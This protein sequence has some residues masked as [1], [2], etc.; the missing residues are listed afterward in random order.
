[1]ASGSIDFSVNAY[2]IITQAC[3]ELGT[4]D[5]HAITSSQL[6]DGLFKLNCLVKQYQSSIFP[7]LMEFSRKRAYLFPQKGNAVYS[8]GVDKAANS[9]VET[10]LTATSP[11]ADTTLTVASI[12]GISAN[13]NIG[14]LLNTGYVQWTTVSGTPSG[15]TVTIATGLASSAAIGARV[16]AYTTTLECPL[17]ILEASVRNKQGTEITISPITLKTYEKIPDKSAQGT[18]SRFYQES[19]INTLDVYFDHAFYDAE[20]VVRMVYLSTID[21][22]DYASD[23]L[24]Y[25]QSYFRFLYYALAIDWAP[26]CK[27]VVSPELQ[28]NFNQS[29]EL[30]QRLNPEITDE[31]YQPNLD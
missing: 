4:Y 1:M 24:D 12:S 14:I 21:D 23:T 6:S 30:V 9:Y 3:K 29:L 18:P 28:A 25:P 31:F 15:S 5:G 19:Q 10:S 26:A 20:Q 13:Q 22:F 2:D 17:R 16:I 27:A 7:G 11:T 8:L